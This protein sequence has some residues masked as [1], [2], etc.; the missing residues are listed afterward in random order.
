[1]KRINLNKAILGVT[2]I[3]VLFAALL[4]LSRYQQQPQTIDDDVTKIIPIGDSITYGIGGSAGGYRF[5]LFLLAHNDGKRIKFVGRNRNEN[6][7]DELDDGTPF[8]KGHAG[9]SGWTID[10]IKNGYTDMVTG[11][12]FPAITV[13]LH[14]TTPHVALLMIGTNDLAG[15]VPGTGAQGAPERLAA[16]VDDILNNFPKLLLVVAAVTPMRNAASAV[17]RFNAEVSAIVKQRSAQGK[18][19]LFVDMY[20]GF[21]T[22][23]LDDGVHPN[24]TGYRFMANTWYEAIK[25]YL[26]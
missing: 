1:M 12:P 4:L 19:V 18:N 17:T 9:H 22:N 15:Y 11:K 24:D 7:K 13:T 20:T 25:N 8:P 3:L 2:V 21:P 16:L 14:K 26:R 10:H 5:P 23:G 6:D